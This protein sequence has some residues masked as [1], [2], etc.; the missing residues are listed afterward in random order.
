MYENRSHSLFSKIP[1][2]D[3]VPKRSVFYF[4]VF[5]A[6]RVG[7]HQS[8]KIKISETVVICRMNLSHFPDGEGGFGGA[9]V[10]FRLLKYVY[11]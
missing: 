6:K 7:S 9:E 8:P 5:H 11:A 3:I 10:Y 2:Q 1:K 4:S